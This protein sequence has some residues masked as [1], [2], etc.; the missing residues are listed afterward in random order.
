MKWLL[1]PG[2]RGGV[3]NSSYISHPERLGFGA[4]V[5]RV[6][7]EVVSPRTA[8]PKLKAAAPATRGTM[9]Q[10]A[11]RRMARRGRIH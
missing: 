9:D 1:S 6:D 7:E 2:P 8:P 10:L 3:W 4:T 11:F 5:W